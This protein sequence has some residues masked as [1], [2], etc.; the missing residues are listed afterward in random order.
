MEQ[1]S[2]SFRATILAIP[3]TLLIVFPNFTD[4][5]NLPKLL[6]LV[7]VAVVAI[8][9]YLSL[10]RGA[11]KKILRGHQKLAVSIYLM[12]AF[13]MVSVAFFANDNLVRS[14]F[15]T[16]GRNNGI[17]Y[18]LACL[19]L[20]V[21]VSFS[22][23]GVREVRY[24]YRA[25]SWTSLIFIF[26]SGLQFLNSD[27]IKWTNP[28]NRVIGTLG[29]PNFSA[30]ALAIFSILWLYLFVIGKEDSRNLRIA[31]LTISLLAGFLSWSTNSVQGPVVILVGIVLIFY[32]FVREKMSSSSIPYFFFLGGGAALSF[33]FASFLGLGPLGAELE[34]YTLRLRGWYASFGLR[35]MLEYPL[36]GI[37]IDNYIAAFREFRPA[38][39]VAKYGVMLTTNNAHSTPAQIGA[40]FGI[41]TFLLFCALNLWILFESLKLINTKNPSLLYRKGIA[42]IW[43]LVLSQSLLSIEIIGLGVINW[44]LGALVLRLAYVDKGESNL[45][46]STSS[47]KKNSASSPAYVAPL[48]IV[49]VLVGFVPTIIIANQ[50]KVYKEVITI[51]VRG[52]QDRD[53]LLERIGRLNSFVLLDQ[54]KVL[55]MLDNLYRAELYEETGVILNRIYNANPNDVYSNDFLASYYSNIRQIDSSIKLRERLRELDP[56]NYQ[57]ELTLAR[58]YATKGDLGALINSVERIKQIAPNSPEYEEGNRLLEQTRTNTS[59]P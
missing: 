8:I 24:V 57:L 33:M 44:I 58:E 9:L 59:N 37:G 36:T 28:Y 35:A 48:A 29:N 38:D 11:I 41:I 46:K 5:I 12:I 42:V 52:S 45:E 43:I 7:N 6:A 31:K 53:W 19:S 16:T 14:I 18:Y 23:V 47:K 40:T 55:R 34:Q 21:I 25:L 1:I 56:M 54:D 4:P 50:D 10:R 15:G 27:P 30:S 32:I 51:Q 17:L 26:Y 22:A 2:P 3:A 13:V 20:A 39:F 49:G